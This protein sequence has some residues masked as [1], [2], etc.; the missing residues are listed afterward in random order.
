MSKYQIESKCPA[1]ASGEAMLVSTRDRRGEPLRTVA[2]LGC[3]LY[4][5]DPLPTIDELKA[6]HELEYRESYKGVRGPKARNVFRSAKLAVARLKDLR[7]RFP[8]GSKVLD[9]G[10]G[11]GEMLCALQAGGYNVT[12][13]EAD[14]VYAE[15]ARQQYGV[16]VR[17]GGVLDVELPAGGFDCMTMFHVLEH[18]PEPVAVLVQMREWLTEGGLLLVEVPNLDSPHQHPGRRFHY[19]HVMGFTPASLRLVAQKAGFQVLESGL[20]SFDRNLFVFL[21]KSSNVPLDRVVPE[22]PIPSDAAQVILYHLRPTTYVRW[23]LRM[24]QF[25]SEL[26]GLKNSGDTRQWISA[27]VGK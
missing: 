24:A 18:Q 2:C 3:G 10:S 19:A 12:G 23:V 16:D 20:S 26:L 14:G 15:H 7:K 11:S 4:R 25:A 13:I 5:N 6:F 8:A 17:V 1:C 9:V 22:K 21:K 27:E